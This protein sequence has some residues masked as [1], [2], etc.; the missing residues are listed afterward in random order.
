MVQLVIKV[1]LNGKWIMLEIILITF[2]GSFIMTIVTT[3]NSV[4]PSRTIYQ[5]FENVKSFSLFNSQI[6]YKF[7]DI[8]ACNY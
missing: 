8:Y 5:Q 7:W 3:A 2:C 6:K 1:K 4:H